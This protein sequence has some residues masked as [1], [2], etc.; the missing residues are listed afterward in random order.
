MSFDEWR[1]EDTL[2]VGWSEEM[3]ARFPT[4]SHEECRGLFLIEPGTFVC[5]DWHC[6]RCGA[7]TNYLGNHACPDRPESRR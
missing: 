3:A 4:A 1:I 2:A 5:R 6:N 7:P